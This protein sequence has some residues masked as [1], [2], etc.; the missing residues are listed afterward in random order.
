MPPTTFGIITKNILQDKKKQKR[1]LPG[2]RPLFCI[3]GSADYTSFR[4]CLIPSILASS[5]ASTLS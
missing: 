1:G 2:G 5:S 3:G 4:S